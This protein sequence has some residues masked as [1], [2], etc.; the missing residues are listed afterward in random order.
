MLDIK[1]KGWP[2]T[3][4]N[5]TVE[6]TTTPI[7]IALRMTASQRRNSHQIMN[8]PIV[9]V[10]GMKIMLSRNIECSSAIS[11]GMNPVTAV[12]WF[13]RCISSTADR[14]SCP[15][16]CRCRLFSNVTGTTIMEIAEPSLETRAFLANRSCDSP[17]FS[18]NWNCVFQLPGINHWLDQKAILAAS[19]MILCG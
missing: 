17:L 13:S 18:F 19:N 5:A 14:I 4:N 3:T 7:E 1:V 2:V 8:S 15:S 12:R 16:C 11:C 6:L 9:T 10:T